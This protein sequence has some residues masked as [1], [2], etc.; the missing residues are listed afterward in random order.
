MTLYIVGKSLGVWAVVLWIFTSYRPLLMTIL[1]QGPQG[2]DL[3][4]LALTALSLLD[5]LSVIAMI[6]LRRI[7]GTLSAED[8]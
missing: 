3:F 2:T 5:L 1:V 8:Q 6:R 4:V 7:S